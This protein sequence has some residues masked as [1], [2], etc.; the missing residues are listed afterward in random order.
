[1]LRSLF[2]RI[3][4]L[5]FLALIVLGFIFWRMEPTQ[6]ATLK[7]AILSGSIDEIKNSFREEVRETTSKIKDD[8]KAKHQEVIKKASDA[9]REELHN[10]VD[11]LMDGTKKQLEDRNDRLFDKIEGLVDGKHDSG[12]T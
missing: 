5:V 11:D 4:G 2:R 6:R 9:V 1:M 12:K 8:V 3:I 7:D 10:Q